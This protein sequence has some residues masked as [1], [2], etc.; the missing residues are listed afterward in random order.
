[1]HDANKVTVCTGEI[2]AVERQQPGWWALLVQ[3]DDGK[4]VEVATSDCVIIK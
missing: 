2:V 1:M 3:C 4:L